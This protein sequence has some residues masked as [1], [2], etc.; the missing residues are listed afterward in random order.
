M[1]RV[2]ARYIYRAPPDVVAKQVL[3]R[4]KTLAARKLAHERAAAAARARGW[5]GNGRDGG[6]GAAQ[7]D[8]GGGS[9]TSRGG[10]TSRMSGQFQTLEEYQA[11]STGLDLDRTLNMSTAYA[12]GV[13][14][15]PVSARARHA[16]LLQKQRAEGAGGTERGKGKVIGKEGRDAV[17]NQGG[18]SLSRLAAV[19][20]LNSR[21]LARKVSAGVTLQ[22]IFR[23]YVARLCEFWLLAASW[24]RTNLGKRWADGGDVGGFEMAV[25]WWSW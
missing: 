2:A 15:V 23:G 1:R 13:A 9:G 16:L 8:S 25:E 7:R 6:V 21:S 20:R 19:Q 22:R 10:T 4:R 24:K 14:G 5:S 18:A 17:L 3:H 12:R 11:E